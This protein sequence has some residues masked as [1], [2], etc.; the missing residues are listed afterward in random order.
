MSTRFRTFTSLC[1]DFYVVPTDDTD[2]PI[3]AAG[4]FTIDLFDLAIADE[5]R[6]GRWTFDVE[7]SKANWYGTLFDYTYAFTLPWQKLP[8][9]PDLTVRVTFLDELT[10]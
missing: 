4:T 2:Q 8:R 9:H 10:Q 6:L 5:P 7:Q 3:K 1:L